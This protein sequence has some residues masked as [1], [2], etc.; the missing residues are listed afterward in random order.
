MRNTTVSLEEAWNLFSSWKDDSLK[1]QVTFTGGG[2]KLPD[3]PL[4]IRGKLSGYVIAVNPSNAPGTVTLQGDESNLEL[5][6]RGGSFKK[7]K[8]SDPPA[9]GGPVFSAQFETSLEVILPS[10]EYFLFLA[11][12]RAN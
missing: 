4:P 12:S 9:F 3:N 11:F 6:L 5:D 8:P 1:V 2:T 10:G 7:F